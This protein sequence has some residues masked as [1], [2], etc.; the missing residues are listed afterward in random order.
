MK[1]LFTLLS[2]VLL[3]ASSQAKIIYLN[4]NLEEPDISQNLFTNWSDAYAS[5]LSGDTIYVSGSAKNYG[6]ITLT[7]Q[8]TLI[9]PG[10]FLS[11][12]SNTQVNK[13]IAA[14]GDITFNG[15]SQGSKLKG[16]CCSG[17]AGYD[18]IIPVSD[19][20]IS[21]CYIPNTIDIDRNDDAN[22]NNIT[23]EK[24]YIGKVSYYAGYD[25]VF[26]NFTFANNIVKGSF[27]VPNG[28]SGIISYN[29]F[30]NNIFRS[31]SNSSF[32]IANNI[33]LNSNTS[34]FNIQPLPDVAVHHNISLTGAFGNDNNNI[35][36]PQSTLFISD[37]GASDDGMYMLS[38]NSPAKG[39]GSNGTDI[40]P[41]GGLDPYRLSGLPNLPNIYEL[42]TGGLVSGDGLP[43]RIK[44]K[45]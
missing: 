22:I 20:F 35:T 13:L 28:S 44:I 7:K 14:F 39:A 24:C 25:G 9:G 33:Y 26:N 11:Q 38:E 31:Q 16:I 36:V 15:G 23:I 6:S 34:N 12:N 5:T 45:Q 8:L 3:F 32:E 10:Y 4:N 43:V 19:I 17:Y 40:G 21:N 18:V 29:L 27:D 37:E 1:T 41:F 30:V 2:I 42:S